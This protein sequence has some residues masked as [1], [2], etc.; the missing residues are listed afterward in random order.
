MKK[1]KKNCFLNQNC[2][3]YED[4]TVHNTLADL[5]FSFI[6][7]MFMFLLLELLNSNMS[8]PFP[9]CY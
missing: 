6:V 1:S 5:A 9:V 8:P 7:M 4:H 3:A 2:I